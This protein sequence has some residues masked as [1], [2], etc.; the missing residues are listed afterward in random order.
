MTIK[1]QMCMVLTVWVYV[2]FIEGPSFLPGNLTFG[3]LSLC[4]GLQ[5]DQQMLSLTAMYQLTEENIRL[6]S[7]VC[8]LLQDIAAAYFPECLIRPFGSTVNGFGKLGCD[9]D[10]FLDL[11]RISGLKVKVRAAPRCTLRPPCL[12]SPPCGHWCQGTRI[13]DTAMWE[14]Q[15]SLVQDGACPVQRYTEGRGDESVLCKSLRHRHPPPP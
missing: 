9:L 8:S 13:G 6:R 14:I 4:R 5:I 11:D 3:L 2:Y 10:M 15:Y 7:L 12:L 1:D